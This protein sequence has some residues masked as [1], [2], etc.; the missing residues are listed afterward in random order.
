MTTEGWE[1]V[2]AGQLHRVEIAEAGL[3]R[4]VTW[5]ID[6][7][8]VATKRTTE[9]R[10]VL[11]P[12]GEGVEGWALAVKLPTFTGPARRVSLFRGSGRSSAQVR[13]ETGVG[14]LD[15][16][17]DPGSKA[18]AREAYIREH[19]R[20]FTA[21][22]TAVG[23]VKVIAPFVLAWLAAR[24]VFSLSW[25]DWL[26]RI[27]WPEIDPP[28]IN[29]PDVD[30]PDIDLPAIPWP[31]V[32]LPDVNVPEIPAWLKWL[33]DKLPLIVPVLV[34]F[35]LARAEV[36]RRR[37]HDDEAA[38]KAGDQRAGS[39]PGQARLEDGDTPAEET[40]KHHGDS[41]IDPSED[42]RDEVN[43]R[44]PPGD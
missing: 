22:S 37:T 10:V 41:E 18:A 32:D 2:E 25:P 3:Q 16:V 40:R 19:P 33:V 12:E 23:V 27:P 8:M 17:P 30:L 13:A 5:S 15:L 7:A 42:S 29:L 28:D 39:A 26:P 44:H 4:V 34:A 21:R 11:T 43:R 20:M 24:F 38:R 6:G 1:R 35:G 9:S 14:G 36:K 31:E